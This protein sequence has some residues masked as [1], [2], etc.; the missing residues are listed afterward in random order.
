MKQ[1]QTLAEHEIMAKM[2]SS[3]EHVAKLE[4]DV[5]SECKEYTTI[6][7]LIKWAKYYFN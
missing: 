6:N 3:F 4:A 7:H 5:M 1:T 2:Q